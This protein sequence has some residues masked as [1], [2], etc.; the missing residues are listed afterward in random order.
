MSIQKLPSGKY[1]ALVRYA[2]VKRNGRAQTTR[3]EALADEARIC[4]EMGSTAGDVPQT[5]AGVFM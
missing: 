2:G 4:L 3:R 1:R 5:D